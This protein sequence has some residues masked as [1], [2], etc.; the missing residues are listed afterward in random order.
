[1]ET[2][3]GAA[4]GGAAGDTQGAPQH[5][6]KKTSSGRNILLGW[7]VFYVIAASDGTAAS[8]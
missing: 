8:K 6:M 7:I 2:H 4:E 1:M 3:A 5:S